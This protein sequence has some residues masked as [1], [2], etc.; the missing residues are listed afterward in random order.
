MQTR[1]YIS[2]I[3]GIGE[4]II[5]GPFNNEVE[6]NL[7]Y[8]YMSYTGFAFFKGI[9]LYSITNEN[10]NEGNNSRKSASNTEQQE[11]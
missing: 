7:T 11:K 2:W 5:A 1:W 10:D 4:T 9:K 8:N 6:A 3:T